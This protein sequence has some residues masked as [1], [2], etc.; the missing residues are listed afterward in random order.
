MCILVGYEEDSFLLAWDHRDSHSVDDA[1]PLSPKSTQ[2]LYELDM[3]S[4]PQR[5]YLFLQDGPDAPPVKVSS[6]REIPEGKGQSVGLASSVS[7]APSS[8]T[9]TNSNAWT[10]SSNKSETGLAP[11]CA[12]FSCSMSQCLCRFRWACESGYDLLP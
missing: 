5:C 6:S 7:A 12:A 8:H 3:P 2:T 10:P 9:F 1:T 11:N 4:E